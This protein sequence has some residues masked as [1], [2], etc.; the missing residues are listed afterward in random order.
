MKKLFIAGATLLLA[1]AAVTGFVAYDRSHA[2]VLLDANVEAL[3]QNEGE[4]I[5]GKLC[6]YSESECYRWGCTSV[7]GIKE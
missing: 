7:P 1:A 3:S 5:V 4:V 2:N 6:V